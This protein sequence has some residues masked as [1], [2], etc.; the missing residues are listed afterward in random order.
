MTYIKD[1][2]D[3]PDRVHRGDF[4]LRLSEGVTKPS[5]TVEDYVVT[6]QLVKCFDE[7]LSLIRASMKAH[8]SKACYLHGSFGSGKSHFMAILYLILTRNTDARSIIE[9]APVVS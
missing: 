8:S 7:A 9:L 5:K 1:L 6:D 2:I 3:L 4:V